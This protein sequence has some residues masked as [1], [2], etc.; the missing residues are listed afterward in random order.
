L[1]TPKST[2][3]L[4]KPG[5][6][7]KTP[8]VQQQ[9]PPQQVVQQPLQRPQ[10]PIPLPSQQQ[11]QLL[12][13]HHHQQQ[14]QQA[15]PQHIPQQ[16]PQYLPLQGAHPQV[17]PSQQQPIPQGQLIQQPINQGPLQQLFDQ[18]LQSSR[19]QT[20]QQ[21]QQQQLAQQGQQQSQS[22]THVARTN[23]PQSGPAGSPQRTQGGANEY[24]VKPVWQ[25]GLPVAFPMG[26]NGQVNVG[27][28]VPPQAQQLQQQQQPPAQAKEPNVPVTRIISISQPVT[29]PSRQ[30]SEQTS[31]PPENERSQV[32]QYSTQP[33]QQPTQMSAMPVAAAP[34]EYAQG[35]VFNP[36]R[37]KTDSIVEPS[38]ANLLTESGEE[39]IHLFNG[40]T[41]AQVQPASGDMTL[42]QM[43]N[44][45][46]A[47]VG[48]SQ[49]A[50]KSPSRDS[51]SS[52]STVDVGEA[53]MQ[54]VMKPQLVDVQRTPTAQSPASFTGPAMQTSPTGQTAAQ[55]HDQPSPLF[56]QQHQPG[57]P[58]ITSNH[59]SYFQPP[60]SIASMISVAGSSQPGGETT[61]AAATPTQT[62]PIQSFPQQQQLSPVDRIGVHLPEEA[63]ESSQQ[64]PLS[65]STTKTGPFGKAPALQDTASPASI[66]SFEVGDDAPK[67]TLEP[68][69]TATTAKDQFLVLP[70][71]SPRS[72]LTLPEGNYGNSDSEAVVP[73]RIVNADGVSIDERQRKDTD[74]KWAKP[75]GNYGGEDWGDD[76]W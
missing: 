51:Y 60:P 42:R 33:I 38:R 5:G 45:S 26:N 66:M 69:G 46:L 64:P 32:Q 36:P 43:F 57:G 35:P 40:G 37:E 76:E 29:L 1:K 18:I 28:T 22:G 75:A 61:S 4:Q 55:I 74:D 17:L 63:V 58:E 49:M 7:S 16:T 54:P 2:S 34:M 15:I 44:A 25:P 67:D 13:Q 31:I 62:R 11:Q 53:H 50:L 19:P 14:Q 12:Q 65:H 9:P 70:L 59:Q 39:N 73:K 10:Q 47:S 56:L 3:V 41:T 20:P 52:I 24:P 6:G 48:L 30:A 72:P 71:F 8:P 68:P 27:N 21:Q 23:S